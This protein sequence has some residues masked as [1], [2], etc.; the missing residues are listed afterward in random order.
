MLSWT[1]LLVNWETFGSDFAKLKPQC[2]FYQK[3]NN[4]KR[5]MCTLSDIYVVVDIDLFHQC[6]LQTEQIIRHYISHK[7]D[8]NVFNIV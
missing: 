4:T 1:Y 6:L 5:V 2:I 7:R 3:F 8:N